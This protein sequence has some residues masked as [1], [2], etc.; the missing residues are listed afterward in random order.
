M[1]QARILYMRSSHSGALPPL[2]VGG[3]GQAAR[4]NLRVYG[5]T[6]SRVYGFTG[7]RASRR[8]CVFVLARRLSHRFVATGKRPPSS[9]SWHPTHSTIN[10]P[11]PGR[12]L[13]PAPLT[14]DW[15]RGHIAGSTLRALGAL[16]QPRSS[17]R[18]ATAVAFQKLVRC[19][20]CG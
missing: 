20:R 7:L 16:G 6:A 17:G 19:C 9:E 1:I 11:G 3:C 5:F 2:R 10:L 14:G 18:A 8:R 13:C 15:G 4:V 12:R